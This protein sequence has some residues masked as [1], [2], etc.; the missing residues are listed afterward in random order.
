MDFICFCVRIPKGGSRSLAEAVKPAFAQRQIFY[1]PDTLNLDGELSTFQRLRF[2][3]AQAKN[4]WRHYRTPSLEKAFAVI[5]EKARG[6]DLI[7][8]GHADFPTGRAHISMPAK[9]ITILRDPM[10]RVVS[11]YHYVRRSYFR[12]NPLFRFNNKLLRKIAGR[13]DFSGYLA[14]LLEHKN[15]YGNIAC[16]YLGWDGREPLPRFFAA[17][18]FHSGILEDNQ[19]FARGLSEK[20]GRPIGFPHQNLAEKFETSV[21]AKERAVAEKIYDR[22]FELY[23]WQK[24]A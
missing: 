1:L 22:D 13:N 12:K 9:I 17:N 2:R 16:R 7:A 8:G 23:A 6:G 15:V 21:G 11:E 10:S 19:A 18:V 3:R 20:L 5:N 4:L 14:F 24:R